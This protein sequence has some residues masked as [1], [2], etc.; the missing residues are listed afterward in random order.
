MANTFR[1]EAYSLVDA[2][3]RSISSRKERQKFVAQENPY[4]AQALG[5]G[6]LRNATLNFAYPSYVGWERLDSVESKDLAVQVSKVKGDLAEMRDPGLTWLY[7]PGGK[8]L[9]DKQWSDMDGYIF[10][11]RDIDA[12][13]S[14]A[15]ATFDIRDHQV[16]LEQVERHLARSASACRDPYTGQ[17]FRW[18]AATKSLWFEPKGPRSGERLGGTNE[19]VGL[20]PY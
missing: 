13:A 7:N 6:M 17:P 3:D 9:V 16:A 15:C 18:D 11:I 8:A 5:L 14:L 20:S 1:L 10:R 19:R 4:V 12:F 2:V